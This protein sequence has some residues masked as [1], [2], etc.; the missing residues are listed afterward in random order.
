MYIIAI[1]QSKSYFNNTYS[2]YKYSNV[3]IQRQFIP[4]TTDL[5]KRIVIS[6]IINVL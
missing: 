2:R 6:N 5:T 4:R 3:S 1:E